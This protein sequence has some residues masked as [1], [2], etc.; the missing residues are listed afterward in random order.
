MI[1][2]HTPRIP[3]I[4]SISTMFDIFFNYFN[5]IRYSIWKTDIMMRMQMTSP[6]RARCSSQ[7]RSIAPNIST[8]IIIKY[9]YILLCQNNLSKLYRKLGDRPVGYWP[10]G[11]K[12]VAS[13]G[14]PFNE[15]IDGCRN[16][17]SCNSNIWISFE[18]NAVVDGIIR[19]LVWMVEILNS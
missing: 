16:P 11:C 19:T 18:K 4:R 7:W 13:G 6:S 15:S 5:Y 1:I 17:I 8:Y 3:S 9:C 12:C 2:V 10:S 14:A